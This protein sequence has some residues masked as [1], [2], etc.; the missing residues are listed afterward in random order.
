[1]QLY[2][3]ADLPRTCWQALARR[4]IPT[5]STPFV[6][7]ASLLRLLALSLIGLLLRN[8]ANHMLL[9]PSADSCRKQGIET[10]NR[11]SNQ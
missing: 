6:I 5:D 3:R 11:F 4:P 2:A 9:L 10:S 8:S 7:L 1:M